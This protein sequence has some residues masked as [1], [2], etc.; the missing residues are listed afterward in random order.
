MEIDGTY[1][2]AVQTRV[3]EPLRIP[4]LGTLWKRQLHRVLEGLADETMP[5]CDQT[6]TPLGREGFFHFT[7]SPGSAP[8]MTA[9][10]WLSL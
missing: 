3:E 2:L 8:L 6:G 10:S 5:S 4:A 7:S 9:R 1:R